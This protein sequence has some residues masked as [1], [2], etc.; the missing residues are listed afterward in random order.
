MNRHFRLSCVED[1][2]TG[3]VGQ[4]TKLAGLGPWNEPA[5]AGGRLGLR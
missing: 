1:I 3:Q 4:T 5:R 2:G